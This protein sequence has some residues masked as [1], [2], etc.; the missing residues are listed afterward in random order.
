MFDVLAFL[1]PISVPDA[2]ASGEVMAMSEKGAAPRATTVSE[3]TAALHRQYGCGQA[4]LKGDAV[5]ELMRILLDDP[6]AGDPNRRVSFGTSG[7]RGSPLLV[8]TV[9]GGRS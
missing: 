7:H 9:I 5:P 4:E 2:P 6:D 3:S 8:D 1:L